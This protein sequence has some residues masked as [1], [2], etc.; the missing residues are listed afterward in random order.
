MK[1]VCK[2][3]LIFTMLFSLSV[4]VIAATIG[5]DGNGRTIK[6][7][8]SEGP[9]GGGK[10]RSN[11]SFQFGFM[12]KVSLVYLDTPESFKEIDSYIL[13]NRIRYNSET[14]E[15][16][17]HNFNAGAKAFKDGSS[18]D[19]YT[20]YTM[21]PGEKC[22]YYDIDPD[23]P[24]NFKKISLSCTANLIE[25]ED[26]KYFPTKGNSS[27]YLRNKDVIEFE[28]SCYPTC[29]A[30]AWFAKTWDRDWGAN[31]DIRNFKEKLKKDDN[32]IF[33]QI[34][35]PVIKN[36]I[37]GLVVTSPEELKRALNSPSEELSE[38]MRRYR[39]IMQP[40][41]MFKSGKNIRFAT[42]KA[43]GRASLYND[44]L[45]G[46]YNFVA[47]G[48]A[49]NFNSA[50]VHGVINSPGHEASLTESSGSDRYSGIG[51]MVVSII[52]D[53]TVTYG[54]DK[55]R[56]CCYDAAGNYHY[57]YNT[58]NSHYKC[59][60]STAAT[61]RGELV[62]CAPAY[63]CPD[64]TSRAKCE[65]SEAT[66]GMFHEND[67]LKNCALNENSKSG[68]DLIKESD[69]YVNYSGS[70][71][72]Y[73]KVS[74]KDDFDIS[75]P[76]NRSGFAG[77]YFTLENSV[78]NIK[79][80]RTCATSKIDYNSFKNDLENL[81]SAIQSSTDANK[82]RY[83]N[84][85]KNVIA[86]YKKCFDW[87]D[88]E[89]INMNNLNMK[90]SYESDT[91]KLFGAG[92]E[93]TKKASDSKINTYYWNSLVEADNSYSNPNTSKEEE[94]LTV[95]NNADGDTVKIK[96]YKN[97]YVKR[98][99]EKT[100]SFSAPDFYSLIPS[101][102]VVSTK[103]S[104][105]YEKMINNAIPLSMSTKQGEYN[106]NI[107][108]SGI[109]SSNR[110]NNNDT[111]SYR[112]RQ[113]AMT[114]YTC[115]YDVKKDI[116]TPPGGTLT[117][118]VGSDCPSGDGKLNFFYR[119]IDMSNI[120]PNNRLLGYNWK[121]YN[122]K[123]VSNTCDSKEC[124]VN[125]SMKE[126]DADYQALV[127]GNKDKFEFILTPGIMDDIRNYNVKETHNGGYSDWKM[128]CIDGGLYNY[129]K[130]NLLT[131]LASSGTQNEGSS[132]DSCRSILST[133]NTSNYK[134][135]YDS[136][137]LL[138]NREILMKKLEGFK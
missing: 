71:K 54:C 69:T 126:T 115:K 29:T 102:I 45:I 21:A 47:G 90:F 56:Q 3:F 125:E 83:F 78:P 87:L 25:Q 44:P 133:H 101:G 10:H 49:E 121:N 9:G 130:S 123:L 105:S 15:P 14:E 122:E 2:I 70:S 8:S 73:C 27:Y 46:G 120:N 80:T 85:Y 119:P 7:D 67:D 88:D 111:L 100:Y 75:F 48:I 113:S 108:I 53:G 37:D 66:T 135:T 17:R 1:K 77:Q 59:E 138:R 38:K 98:I 118:C 55:T 16:I 19:R 134:P 33:Y 84:I 22:S 129:C 136:S 106:Y 58:S 32:K 127:N 109:S 11:Y 65:G 68:F 89:T 97:T 28:T 94:E 50:N 63:D 40:V 86:N 52:D 34:A 26:L 5:Y 60:G 35:Y 116:Y 6:V 61:C 95:L 99:E 39:I 93:L 24:R 117:P 51:Y 36:N 82:Q 104:G 13:I 103:P 110:N 114:D 12:L 41:Y 64:T 42:L 137:E 62:S 57:E 128:N 74:C 18:D 43:M 76:T 124:K 91:Y 4:N 20:R 107:V 23:N 79:I 92:K 131:C 31:I 112:F 96:F 132:F 72:S 81:Q 30:N